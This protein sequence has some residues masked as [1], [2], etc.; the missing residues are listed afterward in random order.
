MMGS[1]V[2]DA[3]ERPV[4]QVT[5]SRGFWMGKYPVTQA[6]WQAV[7][8]SDPSSFKGADLPVETVSWDDCQQ[9]L[10]RL[11]GLEQWTFRLPTEAE[12]EYACRAGTEGERYGDL[13][14]IAWYSGNSGG[15]THPVG[16][17]QPNAW[18][19]HDMNGNVWQWCQD[20]FAQQY[21]A[22]SPAQ[23]PQGP[24]HGSYR[25]DRGGSWFVNA[26]LI[27]SADRFHDTP[28][29]RYS[30]LGFRLVAVARTQ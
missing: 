28:S 12:W 4:H 14:A 9:F 30:R 16:Q 23:D 22:A 21:Y 13:D 1:D 15:S 24:D 19:L 18:G 8:G 2:G 5:I 11:R 20:W 6:Q 10:A 25:V 3:D 29:L 26:R 7:M 17:K 27:R